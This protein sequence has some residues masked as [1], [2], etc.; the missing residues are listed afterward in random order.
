MFKVIIGENDKNPDDK[1]CV[2]AFVVPNVPLFDADL[3]EIT[4]SISQLEKWL[5]SPLCEKLPPELKSTS[6]STLPDTFFSKHD[7]VRNMLSYVDSLDNLDVVWDGLSDALR[8]DQDLLT[9][10]EDKKSHLKKKPQKKQHHEHQ[11]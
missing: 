6:V 4:V 5:G 11:K 2:G 10:D 3:H 7:R 9:V 8:A 1:P